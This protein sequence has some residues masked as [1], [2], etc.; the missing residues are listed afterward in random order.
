MKIKTNS[1]RGGVGREHLRAG[2]RAQPGHLGMIQFDS[3]FS[4][5]VPFPNA[6]IFNPDDPEHLHRQRQHVA[7]DDARQGRRSSSRARRRAPRSRTSTTGTRSS[8]PTS[9]LQSAFNSNKNIKNLVVG[10]RHIHQPDDAGEDGIQHHAAQA[11][12]DETKLR[13][14]RTSLRSSSRRAIGNPNSHQ[15]AGRKRR[16]AISGRST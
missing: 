16:S 3:N 13:C 1:N 12:L 5:T 15:Q 4:E 11:C 2:L 7:D 14:S 9:T 8:T 10:E 6:D